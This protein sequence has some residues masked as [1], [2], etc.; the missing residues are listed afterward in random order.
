[1]AS[2]R[3]RRRSGGA[4]KT[5]VTETSAPTG[6]AAYAETRTWLLKTHG[7]VCAYCGLKFPARTLTLDH[8][9]PRRG[10][11]AYDRRDNL[12]LACKRCNAAKSDKSFLAWVLGARTRALHLF[13]YGQHLSEGILDLLRPMVGDDVP[14][15]VPPPAKSAHK[16]R[17]AKEL[18]GPADDDGDSPYRDDDQAQSPKPAA[19]SKRRSRRGGRRGRS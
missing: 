12:V 3:G 14:V 18:F 6:R 11:S 8:V 4:G 1:M 2:R 19:G 5:R 15:P 10:Q 7:P 16:K 9:T 17:S 13:T